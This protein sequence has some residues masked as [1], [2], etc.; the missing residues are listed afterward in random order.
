MKNNRL[1]NI[2]VKQLTNRAGANELA[3]L[4]DWE[5]QS[6]DNQQEADSL[7]EAWDWGGR[8]EDALSPDV[9]A[10]WKRF[11]DRMDADRR[12]QKVPSVPAHP[13]REAKRVSL[14][15]SR[16]LLRAAAVGAVLLSLTFVAK[17]YLQ[18]SNRPFVVSTTDGQQE[19]VELTDGSVVWLNENSQLT[20]S[21]P[22]NRTE[23]R[24]QLQ[25]EAFFDVQRN[26]DKPFVIETGDA[27]VEVLGTSFNVR[28]V[29]GE[30]MTEVA[31]KTGKV[32]FKATTTE[33][34]LQLEANEKGTF[35]RESTKMEVEQ[36]PQ[37]NALSW[38]SK[39]LS[40]FKT[41]LLTVLK[42]FERLYDVSIELGDDSLADCLYTLNTS[43]EVGLE[44]LIESLQVSY[45]AEVKQ[46]QPRTYRLY[47]GSCD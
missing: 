35:W 18:P 5:Q 30:A 22:N 42:D 14:G 19:K 16:F 26:P 17:N 36:D 27:Q 21:N 32:A 8:Y 38:H 11:K 46:P 39:T 10:G 2:L 3:E 23:R 28:A 15:F 43:T 6:T 45:N 13:P 29:P 47:G 24:V 40:Y 44:Q 9:D 1:V 7:R 34:E 4:R 33:E 25:G 37:L 41:P 20:F 31:V 12:D